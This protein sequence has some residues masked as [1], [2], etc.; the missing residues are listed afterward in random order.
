MRALCK[1]S[2]LRGEFQLAQS[3]TR[4]IQYLFALEIDGLT[5]LMSFLHLT[6]LDIERL[7]CVFCF[8]L[9]VLL[10]GFLCIDFRQIAGDLGAALT[11]AFLHFALTQQIDLQAVQCLS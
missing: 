9:D 2:L 4:Q 5:I 6:Q 7:E 3:L 1:F 10:L 11:K 8:D